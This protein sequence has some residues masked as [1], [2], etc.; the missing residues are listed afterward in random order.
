MAARARKPAPL[1]RSFF[2]R[3]AVTVARDLIGVALM[4]GDTGGVIVETEAYDHTDP[5]SHFYGGRRTPRNESMFGP[6]GQTYVYRSYGV[7]WCLN[8]TCGTEP[9]GGAVLIRAL[10]P[11]AGIEAMKKRRGD[12]KLTQ[13]CAGPGR[14]TQA[15]GITK[16]LDGKPLD[17]PPFSLLP[18]VRGHE[19]AVGQRIGITRGL[20]L[21]WRFGAEGSPFLSRRFQT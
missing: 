9:T 7:H 13:L 16:A 15:L 10:E 6:A 19:V 5:A 3:D 8:F 17:A 4:V 20:D 18:R 1:D 21:Q 11:V 14:L 2:A 12:V